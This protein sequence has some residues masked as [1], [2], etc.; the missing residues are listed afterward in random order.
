MGF[1]G[2]LKAILDIPLDPTLLIE[3]HP[4]QN[5]HYMISHSR[6]LDNN[7]IACSIW[8]TAVPVCIMRIRLQEVINSHAHY[9]LAIHTA[10]YYIPIHCVQHKMK[11]GT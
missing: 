9:G 1:P 4:F 10:I 8:N 2:H 11:A 6:A 3:G 5:R 7:I